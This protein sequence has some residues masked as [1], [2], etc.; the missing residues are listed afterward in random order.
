MAIAKS[1]IHKEWTK[2]TNCY[3]QP[4]GI[5]FHPLEKADEIAACSEN[6][7]TPHD[8]CEENH[9]WHVDDGV[10]ALLKAVDNV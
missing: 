2:G 4:L 3:S 6:Q 5:K 9:E 10:Q 8:L 1:L 7:F